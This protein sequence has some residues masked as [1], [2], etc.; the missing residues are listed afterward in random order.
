MAHIAQNAK[1]SLNFNTDPDGEK[2]AVM[3]GEAH[4]APDAPPTTENPQYLE[5]YAKGITSLE[6]TPAEFAAVLQAEVKPS[7][8]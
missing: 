4:L 8:K 3:L 2:V 7:G 6:M 1:V 5:K